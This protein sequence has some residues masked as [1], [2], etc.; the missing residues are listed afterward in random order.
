[1]GRPILIVNSVELESQAEQ[2]RKVELRASNQAFTPLLL[3]CR[4]STTSTFTFLLLW[5]SQ[6]EELY[7]GLGAEM[8]PFSL[9]LPFQSILSQQRKINSDTHRR[10]NA[11]KDC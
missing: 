2:N 10:Q 1:M 4:Y 8:S 6:H 3:E 11:T 5:L 9:K 7:L